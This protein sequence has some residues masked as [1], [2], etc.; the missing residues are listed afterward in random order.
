VQPQNNIRVTGSLVFRFAAP[1]H[2]P[3]LAARKP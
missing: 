3:H 1:R 2:K